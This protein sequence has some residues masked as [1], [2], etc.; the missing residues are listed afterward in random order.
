MRDRFF[1]ALVSLTPVFL[2]KFYRNRYMQIAKW[3]EFGGILSSFVGKA[4]TELAP[5]LRDWNDRYRETPGEGGED[6]T[7]EDIQGMRYRRDELLSKAV[8]TETESEELRELNLEL[9]QI[10]AF[11]QPGVAA[12][13]TFPPTA[14]EGARIPTPEQQAQ[15]E[16]L[17][18]LGLI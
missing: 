15:I 16:S 2:W 9:S 1:L 17:R 3:I 8:L 6:L 14:V 4:I 13:A 11:S 10:P 18:R 7:A 5:Q 12:P